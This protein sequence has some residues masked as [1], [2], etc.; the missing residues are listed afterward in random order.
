MK[1]LFKK[2][3][4]LTCFLFIAIFGLIVYREAIPP[5]SVLFTTDDNIGAIALRKST[6]PHAFAGGWDD[7]IAA[8]QP[9]NTPVSS[10]NLLLWMMSPR[11]FVNWIHW[12]DLV[13]GSWFLMLFLR[14]RGISWMASV[15][16][17]LLGCWL[18][19]TFFLTYAGH[20][21]KFGVVM[22]AGIYLYLVERAVREKSALYGI[23]SGAAMAGMFIEQSDSA[24]FFALVLGPYAVFRGWQ[25]WRFNLFS[26]IRVIVPLLVVTA[27]ISFHAVYSAYTFFRLDKPV[28]GAESQ[29]WQELWDYC[30][31]WSWPP[32]ESI[33]FIAPGYLGW[34]SG[35][36]S[37]PYWGALGRHPQ[38]RPEFGP[39]GMNFKLETFYKG[40][41]PIMFLALGIYM[42][43][44]RK[45]GG[46]MDRESM[47]FWTTAM[48][49]T[50]I[51]ACGK[52]LPLYRLFFELPGIS[53][54]RNPVKFM[55]ITQIAMAIIAAYGMDYWLKLSRRE[56]VKNDPDVPVV[57]AFS[58][59]MLY[60]AVLF[61]I[62]AIFLLIRLDAS[63][64]AFSA[65]GWQDMGARIA[66]TR[67]KAMFH[68]AIM[69]WIGY[70]VLRLG[71][72]QTDAR[73]GGVRQLG[74]VVIAVVM[75]DQLLIS[76]RY[77][78]STQKNSLVSEG[79]L[80]P[81]LQSQLDHQRFYLWS[82]PNHG[83]W[84]GLFNQWLT[85][86]MPYYQI[87]TIN[88]GQMR[89]SDDY[90]QFFDVMNAR[91]LQMW[92]GMGLGM[93]LAPT[94]F[95]LQVRNDP[96]IREV[97]EPVV[98]YN[99]ISVG[100]T[101]ATTVQSSGGQGSQLVLL[102]FR[103]PSDR[104][105]LIGAWRTEGLN[106]AIQS[107]SQ[108][109]PLSVAIIDPE[110]WEHGADERNPGKAG[111]V[112]VKSYRAGRV[113]LEVVADRPAVLRAAEKFT[114]DWKAWIDGKPTSVHRCDGIFL[115]VKIDPSDSPREII[116]SF[117]P[118]KKTLYLQFAG[119][120]IGL[121]ALI[122]VMVIP[123][124]RADIA[125]EGVIKSDKT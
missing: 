99:V 66:E 84:Q 39:N 96:T 40:V 103:R 55:Q 46:N 2:S 36:Q 17:A 63:A 82:P 20:I 23:L 67:M 69:A 4:T 123:N 28:E 56:K 22:F 109:D 54:I 47:I 10:T 1:N 122:G 114:P 19:S 60:T 87:P 77:V 53:S 58:K 78:Q 13:A 85:I 121:A 92:A 27:M 33:E 65:E 117:S 35:E 30:T 108:I 112:K 64:L 73:V 106:Q 15:L 70:G 107:V 44:F 3:E 42:S 76:H 7:S 72:T 26:H 57:I 118:Q 16:A 34:R 51:L 101:G 120:A 5:G 83:Q 115:G 52:Y 21:G 25:E 100:K 97:F 41:L 38:W 124:R 86:L 95:F 104:F 6:I 45:R 71:T 79:D 116:I 113:V 125:S 50:F 110:G 62:W 59:G 32:S 29:S 105:A 11:F 37:G 48:A 90:K 61:S 89:M 91:P 49:V 18:G 81:M 31:Q 68:A 14:L 43:L 74:L 93:V 94:D 111:M 75:I 88:V 9:I 8:G 98:G 119:M 24:L 12:I 80:I 102:R